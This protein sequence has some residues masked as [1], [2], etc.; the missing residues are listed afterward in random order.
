MSEACAKLSTAEG[1]RLL[2]ADDHGPFREFLTRALLRYSDCVVIG[3]A[4]DG[5]EAIGM[6]EEL[7]PHAVLIDIEMPRLDGIRATRAIH[8]LQ[9][10]V[11]IVGLSLHRSEAMR[12]AM[13]AAGAVALVPKTDRAEPLVH[14]LLAELSGLEVR[15][16]EV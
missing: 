6:V 11:R 1:M 10:G 14:H 8:A 12:Q 3:E 16:V 7:H 4:R 2:I 15:D 5:L 9:P 13:L